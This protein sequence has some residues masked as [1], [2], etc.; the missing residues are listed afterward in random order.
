M[1]INIPVKQDGQLLQAGEIN[2]IV[3]AVNETDIESKIPSHTFGPDFIEDGA[4]VIEGVPIPV[5]KLNPTRVKKYFDTSQFDGDGSVEFPY[6]IKDNII[7]GG[8]MPTLNTPV[9]VSSNITE[10]TATIS[11][12]AI[13][14]AEQYTLQ[15]ARNSGFGVDLQTLQVGTQLSFNDTALTQNTEYWYRVIASA[16]GYINS[17]QGVVNFTTKLAGATTPTPPIVTGNDT[18]NTLIATHATY[19][20]DIVVST[21]NSPYVDYTETILVGNVDRPAG[22]WK[23]KIKAALPGRNES[24]IVS[25]P[26]FTAAEEDNLIHPLVFT[27]LSSGI[28]YNAAANSYKSTY[29]ASEGWGHGVMN[30]GKKLAAGADG[31]IYLKFEDLPNETT[32]L[33]GVGFSTTNTTGAFLGA[34]DVGFYFGN[35][36]YPD[37]GI[38]EGGSMSVA[39]GIK[40]IVGYD[41]RLYRTAGV[42][43][44]QRSNDEW[45]TVQDLKIYSYTSNVDLYPKAD[46]RTGSTNLPI[47]VNPRQSKLINI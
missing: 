15:R 28:V 17:I 7:G 10:T 36:Q 1:K 4:E 37:L 22:Y 43:K 31:G 5:I 9:P 39:D 23:F 30:A 11:W 2:Q 41:Y 13:L 12:L 45:V 38:V 29:V 33:S 42:W 26:V 35:R 32:L 8:S 25:S 20:N 21:N 6:K 16:T 40:H 14:H 34:Y 24:S 3:T 46:I 44:L 27:I 19:P 47:L 18:A